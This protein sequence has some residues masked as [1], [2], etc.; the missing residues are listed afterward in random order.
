MQEFLAQLFSNHPIAAPLIFI[1]IRPIAVI[2]PPIPGVLMDLIAIPLFGWFWAFIYS[3]IGSMIGVSIAFWIAR[4]FREPVVKRFVPLQKLHEWEDRISEHK[5]F[6][7]FVALRLPSG[8]L[9]DWISYAA[10][11]TKM[12]FT[13]FFF[14]T[15]IGGT[16]L[17]FLFFYFGGLAFQ[18][19]V[20]YVIVFLIAIIISA[21]IFGK[22]R[23]MNHFALK[24][25]SIF[26]LR[27]KEFVSRRLHL[28]P[29]RREYSAARNETDIQST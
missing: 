3:V 18:K 14:A 8:I 21:F 29:K 1:I 26:P 9:I 25:Q 10:G 22:E 12:R 23:I 19:G 24:A 5:K 6:L 4:I 2:I 17:G 27:G 7:L 11:L 15:L 16:P 13:S 28:S 20:Y